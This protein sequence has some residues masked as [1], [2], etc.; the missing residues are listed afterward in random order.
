MRKTSGIEDIRDRQE[1]EEYYHTHKSSLL[2]ESEWKP[3]IHSLRLIKTPLEIG[4]IQKAL[5]VSH[6]TFAH[7]EKIIKP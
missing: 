7:I 4:K 1:F 3:M 6:E 5:K 2:E